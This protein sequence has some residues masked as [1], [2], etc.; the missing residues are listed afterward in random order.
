MPKFKVMWTETL[1][2]CAEIEAENA[3]AAYDEA[4][5]R[6]R[7]EEVVLDCEDYEGCQI[8]VMDPETEDVLLE[9]IQ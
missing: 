4:E 5:R 6:Y 3:D 9:G 7:N 8:Q 2:R 1:S